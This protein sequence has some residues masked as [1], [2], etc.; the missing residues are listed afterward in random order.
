MNDEA[1]RYSFDIIVIVTVEFSSKS[2]K[3]KRLDSSFLED[4]YTIWR[5][6]D[7]SGYLSWSVQEHHCNLMTLTLSGMLLKKKV[8]RF[9]FSHSSL[10]LSRLKYSPS[11]SPHPAKHHS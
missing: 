3:S 4:G 11:G 2:G 1:Q 6:G 8:Q 10:N 5:T 9:R 7:T